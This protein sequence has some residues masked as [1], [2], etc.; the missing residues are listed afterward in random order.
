MARA[1][2]ESQSVGPTTIEVVWQRRKRASTV[3]VRQLVVPPPLPESKQTT[4]KELAWRPRHDS[5]HQE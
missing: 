2:P 5:P 4:N 1:F 3:P